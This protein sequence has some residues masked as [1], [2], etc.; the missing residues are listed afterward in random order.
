[1]GVIIGIWIIL[2]FIVGSTFVG[3]FTCDMPLAGKIASLL[4]IVF[5]IVM[6]IVWI[7]TH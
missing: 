2:I 5:A 7:C 4:L 1:M 6:M 3:V